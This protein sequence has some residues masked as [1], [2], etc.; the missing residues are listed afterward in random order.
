MEAAPREASAVDVVDYSRNAETGE[1]E[2]T[3]IELSC[4]RRVLAASPSLQK[5]ET[6]GGAPLPEK[7][8]EYADD[9][10]AD[11]NRYRGCLFGRVYLTVAPLEI[12]RAIIVQLLKLN[13]VLTAR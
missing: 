10:L 6:F 1:A 4:V 11:R 5:P 7:R 2:T 13:F 9:L 12:G 8:S 3:E